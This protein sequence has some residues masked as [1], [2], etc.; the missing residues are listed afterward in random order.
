M[1]ISK[2]SQNQQVEPHLV[3]DISNTELLTGGQKMNHFTNMTILCEND[4]ISIFVKTLYYQWIKETFKPNYFLTL[5]LPEHWKT[6]NE[7]NSMSKVRLIMKTFEKKLLKSHW[8][9]H[10]L[11]FIVFSEKGG[12]RKWHYHILLNDGGFDY[13]TLHDAIEKTRHAFKFSYYNLKLLKIKKI[14]KEQTSPQ[15]TV[16][17]YCTKEINVNNK[18]FFNGDR[19]T[20]SSD[21]F[22]LPYNV[23]KYQV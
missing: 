15:K 3:K 4:N 11:P 21:L 2:T 18:G 17:D 22:Y 16:C 1:V 20:F 5:Q 12:S 9:K 8:N 6:A 14:K 10:H 7:F 13:Y 23:I 19:V